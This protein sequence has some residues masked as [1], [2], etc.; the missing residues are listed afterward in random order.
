LRASSGVIV[1]ISSGLLGSSYVT[2]I[3]YFPA[4]SRLPYIFWAAALSARVWSTIW[5]YWFPCSRGA[6]AA[7]R[8]QR[9]LPIMCFAP[10]RAGPGSYMHS[11]S[12]C[13]SWQSNVFPFEPPCHRSVASSALISATL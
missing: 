9:A 4:M 11:C 2:V 12:F 7:L 10:G 5:V 8:I 1:R 13:L 3:A 6:A